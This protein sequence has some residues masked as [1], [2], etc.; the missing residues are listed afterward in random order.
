LGAKTGINV[1]ISK[2]KSKYSLF[3]GKKV[4]KLSKKEKE[5]NS[6]H[7]RLGFFESFKKQ[8]SNCQKKKKKK[9]LLILGLG[10]L[11]LLKNKFKKV[12]LCSKNLWSFNAKP[13]LG[14]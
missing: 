4:A 14:I 2:K 1:K 6:P 10:F 8:V 12:W 3:F 5:K 9:I 7:F 11:S 13:L